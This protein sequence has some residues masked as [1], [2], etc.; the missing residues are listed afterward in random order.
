MA[1]TLLHEKQAGVAVPTPQY[2][3]WQNV[4]G[5]EAPPVMQPPAMGVEPSAC[6]HVMPANHWA[7]CV[8]PFVHAFWAAD[9][10]EALPAVS[11]HKLAS[12]EFRV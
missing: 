12:P 1:H 2:C 11:V 10:C 4:E 9:I 8:V 6:T 7:G 3:V 5:V